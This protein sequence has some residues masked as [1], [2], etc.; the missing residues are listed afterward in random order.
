MHE[1]RTSPTLTLLRD[2]KVLVAGGYTYEG[3][4]NDAE[5]YNPISQTFTLT[6]NVMS[7]E[8]GGQTATLLPDGSVLL[9]GGDA[10]GMQAGQIRDTFPVASADLYDPDTR[11][12]SPTQGAMSVSR[13]GHTANLV[14][15]P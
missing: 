15:S 5:L 4:L 14:C 12:F 2:G 8:R 10:Q 11:L 7:S 13:A 3:E 6:D 9:A 1:V